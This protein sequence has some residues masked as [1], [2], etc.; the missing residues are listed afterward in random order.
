[1]SRFRTKPEFLDGILYHGTVILCLYIQYMSLCVFGIWFQDV[2]WSSCMMAGDFWCLT[3]ALR[4]HP[5]NDWG[6]LKWAM[7]TSS[8]V[9]AETWDWTKEVVICLSLW[10]VKTHLSALKWGHWRPGNIK[11]LTWHPSHCVH[12]KHDLKVWDH[13][14]PPVDQNTDAGSRI[15]HKA[16][17]RSFLLSCIW[18]RFFHAGLTQGVIN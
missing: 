8:L 7:P 12:I 14:G 6:P 3:L 11:N 17:T 16:C 13:K 5:W 4:S 15:L 18:A 10:A 1:M 2:S 9:G